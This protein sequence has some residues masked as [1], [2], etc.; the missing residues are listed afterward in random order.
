MAHDHEPLPPIRVPRSRERQRERTAEHKRQEENY[1]KRQLNYLEK[2]R[3]Q[4]HEPSLFLTLLVMIVAIVIIYL[5]V[6]TMLT[7]S[8][9]VF[10]AVP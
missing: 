2:P 3:T 6:T 9:S 10:D 8:V 5:F 4:T 1:L 7:P